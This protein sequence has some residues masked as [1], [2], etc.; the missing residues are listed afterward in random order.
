MGGKKTKVDLG[1]LRVEI[2]E[3]N[4]RKQLYRVLKEELSKI[5]HWKQQGRGN[6]VKAFN[7]R[8][9]KSNAQDL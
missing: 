7:T 2:R 8:G 4:N 6:P 1:Q 3:L 9:R 5:D